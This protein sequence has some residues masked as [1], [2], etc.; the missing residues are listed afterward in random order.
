MVTGTT[1]VGTLTFS[2]L[3]TSHG[4]KYSCQAVINIPDIDLMK[5]GSDSTEVKVQSEDR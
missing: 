2:S 4:A 5:T 3:N 1:V